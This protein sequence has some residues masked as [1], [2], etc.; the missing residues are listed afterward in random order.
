MNIRLHRG[1][2]WILYQYLADPGS[3]SLEITRSKRSHPII[4][5][6]TRETC[7]F[8][9]CEACTRM[10]GII[11]QIGVP[12]RSLGIEQATPARAPE[13]EAAVAEKPYPVCAVQCVLPA[14]RD[15]EP[16]SVLITCMLDKPAADLRF[17]AAKP[18]KKRRQFPRSITDIDRSLLERTS[19]VFQHQQIYVVHI[20]AKAGQNFP[21]LA[22]F[23]VKDLLEIR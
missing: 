6:L 4:I 20:P 21:F 23:R 11:C 13:K 22:E 1:P 16:Q 3:R 15:V 10:L 18:T 5:L 9:L 8:D 19:V 17:Q 12:D 14:S 2:A 7:G